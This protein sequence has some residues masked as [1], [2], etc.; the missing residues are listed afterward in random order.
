MKIQHWIKGLIGAVIGGAANAITMAI[1]DPQTFN[2]HEGADKL[3]NVAIV[4]AIVSGAMYLK[5]S[6]VPPDDDVKPPQPTQPPVTPPTALILALLLPFFVVGC[7]TTSQSGNAVIAGH[8]VTPESL[9]R[10]IRLAAK[11]GARE[12]CKQDK[13]V[14]PYL[15]AVVVALSVALDKGQYDTNTLKALLANVSVKEIRSESAQQYI[16][17]ALELYQNHVGDQVANQ[18]DKVRYLRPALTGL[19]DGIQDGLAQFNASKPQSFYGPTLRPAGPWVQ[20]SDVKFPQEFLVEKYKW[21]AE[22]FAYEEVGQ[23]NATK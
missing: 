18:I 15:Q 10:D 19:R 7:V 8:E 23:F 13:N 11:I 12:G 22:K 17:D 21:N 6:P 2:I 1:V 9:Q 3:C 20:I 14:E 4:S 16:S 5:Q